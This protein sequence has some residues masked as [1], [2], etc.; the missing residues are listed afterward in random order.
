MKKVTTEL[1]QTRLRLAELELGTDEPIAI[2]GMACRFPGGVSNPDQLW[3]LV[4]DGRDA[5]SGFPADRGWDLDGLTGAGSFTSVT[6]EGGFLDGVGDF[7]AEFF[8][9]SPREAIAMDPQQRLLLETSWEALEHAGTD[10]AS[11]TG[12]NVGVF[13]GTFPSGYLEVAGRSGEDVA[14]HLIT[15][16]SQSV[17]SG[18]VAYVLGLQ[19]PALT[20]D[21]ACS[22]S[23][24]AL[25]LAVQALRAGE[26]TMALAGGVSVMATPDTFV[27]FSLQGGMA[28]DGRCKAFADGADGTGWSEGAGMLVVQRLSD[29]RREG[30]RVLAVVR[31]SAVNQDGASNGLTAPNGPAQ[32]RVIRQALAG[33]GLSAGEIDV[34]EA[35]GT[36]TVLGDPIEAQALL[37]T[38]GQDR[39]A[40]RPVL[41][42]SLKSNLGHTQAA[43]GVAGV[44]KMVM[45]IRHG[46]VPRTL[47]V[48]APSSKVDWSQGAVRL[49]TDSTPWPEAGRPRRAGVSS[50][51]VSGT[52]AHVI[53]EAAP[54]GEAEAAAEP[55]TASATDTDTEAAPGLVRDTVPW[56]LS[57]RTDQAVRAQAARLLAWADTDPAADPAAVGAALATTRTR[58]DNRLV[59]TGGDRAELLAVLRAVV[60]GEPTPHAI[61]GHAGAGAGS[62]AVF[63]FP[64]QGAQWVG[65]A[66]E[67]ADVSPVFAEAMT[68]CAK[69]LDPFVDWSLSDVLDDEAALN[70]VQV[71]QPVLWA[72][73]VSLAK[74]W[75]SCGV[76]PAAVVGHSQGEIAAL[77]V[78]GG[79]SLSDGARIVALR[80]QAIADTLAGG[81]GMAAVSLPVGQVTELIAEWRGRLCV[82][83]VN[84]PASVVVSGEPSALREFLAHCDGQEIRARKIPV[85]YASH[86]AQVEEIR[87]RLLRELAPVRP[88]SASVPVYSSV[89]GQAMDTSTA[90]AAYWVRNLRETVRF[91]QATRA[92]IADGHR[93]LIEVSPHPVLAMSVQETLESAGHTGVVVGTLRRGEGGARRMVASLA[94]LFVRGGRVSW[95]P[96]FAGIAARQV[97]PPTYA[98]QHQRYWPGTLP[99]VGD[100][101]GAGLDSAEHPLLGAMVTLPESGGML[102]T[103]RLSLRS[104]PW[105]ADHRVRGT[106]VFP[107]TGFVELALRVGDA[108]GCDRIAELVLEEPLTLPARGTRQIQIALTEREDGWS[109]AIHA[110]QDGDESWTRHATGVLTGVLE[111]GGADADAPA[112]T[113]PWP[114]TDATAIDTSGL[115]DM[116]AGHEVTYGPVFQG[117]TRAW[118]RGDRVWAEVVLPEVR[119][120]QAEAF[121]VHPALLDAVLHA[122]T[123][124]GLAPAES[125]RLPFTF[126]DV[127]LRAPGATRV[128]VSLARTGPDEV[129]IAV[130]DTTGAPVLSIGSMVTRPLPA[131]AFGAGRGDTT[132]TDSA[133]DTDTV[134]LVPQWIDPA[135]APSSAGASLDLVVGSA[136]DHADFADMA[137]LLAAVDSGRET[138][139]GVVLVVPRG[140][141]LGSGSV[142]GRVHE[143]TGWVLEQVRC[144]LDASRLSDSRLVVVTRGAVTTG[145]GDPVTDLPGAAVWGLVRS[146]QTENP[147][148]I[149]LVDLA[150]Q[151]DP[152]TD[153]TLDAV[154]R[155]VACG[156]SQV[157][158]REG[159]VRVLRLVQDSEVGGLVPPVGGLWRLESVGGGTLEGLSLVGVSGLVGE[160]GVG[161]V[162]IGV[163]AAGVNFRDVLSALGMYPGD[164]GLLGGEVSGVVLGVGPGVSRV[165]VGDRV[166]GMV[167]G[168]F[169]PV[170]VT[171]ERLV[172]GVPEGW[173]FVEAAGVPIAFLTAYYGLVD[174]AGVV[175]GESLL[176][177]AGAGGVGMA[178]IQLA[179]HFGLEVFAT[180]SES[181][182]GVLRSLGVDDDHVGSSRSV[183]FEGRFLGVSG[184]RGVDVVLNS[185]A[186]EFVDASLRLLA[187]RGRFIEMGKTDVRSV[188][189]VGA[190]RRG[191]GYQAFDLIDAGPDRIG[192]MLGE[193]MGL[194][195][196]GVLRP[197]PVVASDVRGARG[198]FRLMSQARHTGKLV[199]TMPEPVDLDGTVV[200]TGGTGGLGSAVARHLV[201]THGVRNLVLASRRG[202]QA[203]GATA[204]VEELTELGARTTVVACDVS[205]RASVAAL[206]AGVPDEHPLTGVVHTAGV[207]DDGVIGSLTSERLDRVLAPKVDATWHLHELTRDRELSFFVVFSS[208]AGLMGGPGQ[209]NYAAG[210]VFADTLVQ[211]RRQEGLPGVSMAWGSW[212]TEVGLT[213]TLSGIDLQRMAGAGMLP[214]SVP[215]GLALFDRALLTDQAVMGLTRWRAGEEIPT[216]KRSS[217][218]GGG[219][220]RRS[221]GRREQ[222]GSGGGFTERWAAVPAEERAGFLLELVR[223]HAAAVL[224]H[225][226]PDAIGGGQVF[227][228]LGFDSLTAVELR[229]RLATAT[230]LSLPATLVFDHPTPGRVVTYLHE[231][232]KTDEPSATE[233]VLTYLSNLKA[234]FPAVAAEAADRDR[235]AE[236]LREILDLCG[237]PEKTD[238]DD[239]DTASDE[240]LFAFVDQGI[241]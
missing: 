119:T 170:V 74:L 199:L 101:V 188:S 80:S 86:S 168:G 94:E 204:L 120:G 109:L 207:L 145:E 214:L 210:N 60:D 44:I 134:V 20:V 28:A 223:G 42:G 110:R 209:A 205:D 180:A 75:R 206:L 11:L 118:H 115:Y 8:G 144:W 19:G 234:T 107:G 79:L 225:A 162:R 49:L 72:V 203:E 114:P 169:G 32:Q 17:A 211:L 163:R 61:Q 9:I 125:A 213:G 190:V 128:R 124:A 138:P 29:A 181:K 30:R 137:A 147:D 167:S 112:L 166:L 165:V 224:G 64:G 130:A 65:M 37:A 92:L 200:V 66:R 111:D 59:V 202:E 31:S 73:M 69:A 220:V 151:G 81:G 22:S 126:T 173:S 103:G 27:G 77:C 171:D 99:L 127:V 233:T 156:E 98:F 40:D 41:L 146:A 121:G 38:Y 95:D 141:V 153:T 82:A 117:L 208:L 51:G 192:E 215:Q 201:R 174:L 143:V 152:D 172:V 148:R 123:F 142:V 84:G 39:P 26:C 76:E 140:G 219:R 89:T 237:E 235:I 178:A 236:R 154:A 186:G 198:V 176:V 33:A 3:D 93:T 191:V 218:M 5:I 197:L 228:D 97:E 62:G 182:W 53:L 155:A 88:R 230:G 15:G 58:F 35:H 24:V 122:A 217:G 68:E 87:D 14:G 238:L 212:T 183:D 54:Q 241:D 85:D 46:L 91:E 96:V 232:L 149:T 12:S 216:A 50:F 4:A 83:A 189:D 229:N 179:G 131:G 52:N 226:S 157:A 7:D 56:V 106:A 139:R 177:H 16:G 1:H 175:P 71:V 231:Q 47:H 187:D 45:A 67:L 195:E 78:A 136:T 196:A 48:D 90:D 133:T 2:V 158:V 194:F 10:P 184:G 113:G 25:H 132:G 102:F 105:L 240:D 63:V 193:L 100:V 104:H 160:L 227:R 239:V 57:G 43:A 150:D 6:A 185:L 34:V 129:S 13:V 116:E 159:A 18:R 164:A 36:G 70:R 221:G 23:L 222:P 55:A 161:E 108:V 135:G 21:T